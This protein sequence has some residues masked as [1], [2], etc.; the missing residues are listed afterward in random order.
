MLFEHAF[1]ILHKLID[2]YISSMAATGEQRPSADDI[3]RLLVAVLGYLDG[4]ATSISTI[5]SISQDVES[6]LQRAEE[7]LKRLHDEMMSKVDET[8]V[9]SYRDVYNTF[10]TMAKVAAA[11]DMT[12]IMVAMPRAK[13]PQ[14][15]Y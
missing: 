2:K 10:N 12:S 4:F 9:D 15:F 13:M 8:V 7:E 5:G 3:R 11:A 6:I 1:S 14:I